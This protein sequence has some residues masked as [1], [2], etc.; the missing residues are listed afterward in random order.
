MGTTDLYTAE[1]PHGL[2]EGHRRG[3]N[4]KLSCPK[5]A[6]EEFTCVELAV[7]YR[8]DYQFQK[9]VDGDP[10]VPQRRD[11]NLQTP[12][13]V[14][15]SPSTTVVSDV[16]A[17]EPPADVAEP[18]PEEAPG[19]NAAVRAWAYSRGV[20][21]NSRGSV[22]SD[23]R[24]AYEAA[25]LAGAAT[26][27]AAP[28]YTAAL[29]A[30]LAANPGA[31]IFAVTLVD[32]ILPD[33]PPARAAA[34]ADELSAADPVPLELAQERA[35]REEAEQLVSDLRVRNEQLEHAG[36][37]LV[38]D[39]ERTIELLKQARALLAN[40]SPL[41]VEEVGLDSALVAVSEPTIRAELHE[42]NGDWSRT[43]TFEFRAE[44]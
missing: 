29:A 42:A 20:D 33:T 31:A 27:F 18:R 12:P 40:Y 17:D 5:G 25:M 4:G 43:L 8:S 21:V 19:S 34:L 38:E 13:P 39:L 23:V 10:S 2:L 35:R 11:W 3:C 44:P 16:A 14:E 36:T 15:Q 6:T 26:A 9:L 37:K 32:E 30:E 22:R 41:P 28:D 7:L 24:A 1:F